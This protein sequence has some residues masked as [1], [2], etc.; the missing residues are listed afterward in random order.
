MADTPSLS[1]IVYSGI[2][3]LS[4]LKGY[5]LDTREFDKRFVP[6]MAH[7]H[8]IY[9]YHARFTYSLGKFQ[10][11]HGPSCA[12]RAKVLSARHGGEP[13]VFAIDSDIVLSQFPVFSDYGKR[14]RSG[15][16]TSKI[17]VSAVYRVRHSLG[18]LLTV[19]EDV[20]LSL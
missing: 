2:N 4:F 17:A 16:N 12:H 18:A 5:N 20:S 9:V 13:F 15:I 7:Q 6:T 19:L 14:N 1:R 3:S 11:L 8:T 10:V